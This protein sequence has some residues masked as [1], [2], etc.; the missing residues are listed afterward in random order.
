MGSYM[1]HEYEDAPAP[2]EQVQGRFWVGDRVRVVKGGH[3]EGGSLHV[4][5]I[6]SVG[7]IKEYEKDGYFYRDDGWY[8]KPHE[9]AP[10]FRPGDRVKLN[11]HSDLYAYGDRG[12]VK[13]VFGD[14][15][16][17]RMD[18]R[19]VFASRFNVFPAEYLDWA[20]NEDVKAGGQKAAA[21][22]CAGR[23]V[24]QD[25]EVAAKPKFKAG[26]VVRCLQDHDSEFTKGKTYTVREYPTGY[27]SVGVVADDNCNTANGW[28]EEYFELVAAHPCIVA[29]TK[30]GN[31]LPSSHPFVHASVA[32]A[33]A[34]AERLARNNP[35]EEFAVY[36]RVAGRQCA[37]S[38]EMKEVA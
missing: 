11:R 15:V 31:P 6:G 18:L 34:E 4:A 35:G 32:D 24:E 16:E 10:A 8:F 38:Y 23:K 28:A 27:G 37:V 5:E 25:N 20:R 26:D 7:A 36:Q 22:D 21:P 13:R 3:E 2:A 9:L 14:N 1:G 17:V 29:L 33:T 30:N 19:S 12:T